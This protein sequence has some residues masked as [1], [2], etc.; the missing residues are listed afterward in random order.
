[1]TA[2][3]EIETYMEEIICSNCGCVKLHNIPKGYRI[4]DYKRATKCERCGCKLS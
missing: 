3:K 1:M 4:I 2:D